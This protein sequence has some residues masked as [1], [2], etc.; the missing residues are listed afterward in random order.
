MT[1]NNLNFHSNLSPYQFIFQI[2]KQFK[3]WLLL[4]TFTALLVYAQGVLWPLFYGHITD[5]LTNQANQ[6][7]KNPNVIIDI[8]FMGLIIWIID[9]GGH[10]V[11][12]W[13]VVPLA[14][15]ITAFIRNTVSAHI[16]NHSVQFYSDH[17][18]GSISTK[19][20]DLAYGTRESILLFLYNIIPAAIKAFVLFY[21]FAQ[22]QI[23]Y[24]III[25][26]WMA[27]VI[28]MRL[29]TRKKVESLSED[30]AEAHSQWKGWLTDVG[31]SIWSVKTYTGEKNEIKN[32]T[33]KQKIEEKNAVKADR[34]EVIL[35]TLDLL[36]CT[37]FCYVA[38]FS[39]LGW[40]WMNDQVT[41]GDWMLIIYGS[42]QIMY[43]TWNISNNLPRILSHIGECQQAI[44]T[45]FVPIQITDKPNAKKLKIKNGEIE[46][47]NVKFNYTEKASVFKKKSLT[48]EGGQ[49]IGLVGPSGAGKTSFVN[50][51]LRLFD[52]DG[53][54]ITIDG[55]DIRDVTQQSL[56]KQIAYIPQDPALFHRS[57]MENIRYGNPKATKPQVY[58][59]AK[60]A[61]IHKFIVGLE[62]GYD[63]LVGERGVKLSGGQRQRIAIARAILKDAPILIIDEG[64][65]ALDS[66]TEDNVQQA[67]YDLMVGRTTIVIAHRLSTL[68]A[69][70]RLL[71][72]DKGKVI[73]DG[74]HGSLL[75]QKDKLYSVLWNKQ[76]NGFVGS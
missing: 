15:R 27:L 10:L 65:S 45:L 62:K 29:Y 3:W 71:V 59:A 60:K 58:A 70:D 56:R 11:H 64:T 7:V 67:L 36:M 28:A 24:S 50:L 25:F 14:P 40:Q 46:F 20:N 49:K 35:V 18:S 4:T 55:Q 73:Q 5:T 38:L 57:L 74:T 52:V 8:F 61:Q 76:V 69:M 6:S 26:T 30:R 23:L 72:M 43:S 31:S 21:I 19:V 68:K 17:F 66:V 51:I 1:A 39:V 44:K 53:G 48:I 32:L 16:L 41:A 42:W 2:I 22:K 47:K 33:K 54:A 37:V 9:I 13:L 75:R 63:T 12:R 34:F